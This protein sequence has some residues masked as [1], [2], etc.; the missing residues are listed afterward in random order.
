[1]LLLLVRRPLCPL[2]GCRS[3][4]GLLRTLVA[5]AGLTSPARSTRRRVSITH[6]RE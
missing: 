2:V 3:Q 4:P 5:V 1:M 6:S